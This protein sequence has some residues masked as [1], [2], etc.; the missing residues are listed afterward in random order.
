M[1]TQIGQQTK[2]DATFEYIIR[3]ESRRGERIVREREIL[4]VR[5]DVYE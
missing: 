5:S 4:D 3:V 2:E 1:Y